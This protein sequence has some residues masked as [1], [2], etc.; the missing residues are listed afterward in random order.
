[1]TNKIKI[2]CESPDYITSRIKIKM[3][4]EYADYISCRIKIKMSC[5]S[6]EYFSCR[7]KSK[8]EGDT[9]MVNQR[10]IILDK[11]KQIEEKYNSKTS[12]M[13]NR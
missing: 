13:Q 6:T 8:T 11:I 7:I 12:D 3:S 2:S 9:F 4:C 5:E 10:A 1:M